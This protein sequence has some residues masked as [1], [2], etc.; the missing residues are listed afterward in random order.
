[1]CKLLINTNEHLAAARQKQQESLVLS[2]K[3]VQS[4][5]HLSRAPAIKPADKPATRDLI[6]RTRIG[7][8]DLFTGYYR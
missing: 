1:M 8:L 3:A 4:Y 7:A 2:Y 5:L 6:K